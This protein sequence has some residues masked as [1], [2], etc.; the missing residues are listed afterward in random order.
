MISHLEDLDFFFF[1][2]WFTKGLT[3]FFQIHVNIR[4]LNSFFIIIIHYFITHAN[5]NRCIIAS[6]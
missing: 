5:K 2:F 1:F 6:S 3:L 4:M